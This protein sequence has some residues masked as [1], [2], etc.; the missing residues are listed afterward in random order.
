VGGQFGDFSP[1]GKRLTFTVNAD[2]RVDAYV[3]EVAT[4]RSEKIPVAGGVNGF[5][6]LPEPFSRPE[7]GCC[8]RT[9]AQ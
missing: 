3:A 8:C 5:C 2:G 7:N 6:R 9:R 4:M 1:D